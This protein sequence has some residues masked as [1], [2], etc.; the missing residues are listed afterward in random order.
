MVSAEEFC[1]SLD[2]HGFT[3]CVGVPCS[4]FSG[5]TALLGPRYVAAAD[6]GAA[7]AMAAG[8]ALAGSRT[9][10]LIQN[11]G[12]GNLVNPLTSLVLPYRI[13]VVVFMSLRGWPNPAGDEPQHAVMGT[14]SHRLLDVLGVPHWTVFD[15]LDSVLGAAVL[16]AS[17]GSPAFVLVPKGVVGTVAFGGGGGTGLTRAD[18]VKAVVA[19]VPPRAAIVS[20]TG[21]ASRELCAAGDRPG[22]FYMQGSMGHAPAIALGAALSAPDRPV[23]V[24]D[25]DGALLMHLG[26][27]STIGAV[28]PENLVHV[29]LDNGSYEST[30][31]QPTTARS[32]DFAAVARATGY[33]TVVTCASAAELSTALS[34]LSGTPGPQ[35]VVVSTTVQPDVTPPR[36]TSAVPPTDLAP[37]FTRWL[38]S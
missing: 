19:S 1:R 2:E 4:Y 13:G 29:V 9:G 12:F 35:M 6:E 37:R 27:M 7:L 8:S 25:G 32:T 5:P 3:G 30:G 11:S 18:A 38:T 14:S 24:L 23:V 17:A 31:A 21:Y 15:D 28:A 16:A 33:R 26:T 10:V 34:G 36:V 20:T 22:N